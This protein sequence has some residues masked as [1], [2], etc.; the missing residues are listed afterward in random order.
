ML[1]PDAMVK[2]EVRATQCSSSLTQHLGQ[3]MMKPTAMIPEARMTRTQAGMRRR[4]RI[5]LSSDKT[6]HHSFWRQTRQT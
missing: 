4:P 1:M 5:E 3:T 6:L 2:A